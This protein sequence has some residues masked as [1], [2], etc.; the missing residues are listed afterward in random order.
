MHLDGHT[1]PSPIPVGIHSRPPFISHPSLFLLFFLCQVASPSSAPSVPP[2]YITAPWPCT[3]WSM[4]LLSMWTARQTWWRGTAR[5]AR[6]SLR[7]STRLRS[8]WMSPRFCK[9]VKHRGCLQYWIQ[10]KPQ[11]LPLPPF[12]P[13]SFSNSCTRVHS[14]ILNS[15]P[16]F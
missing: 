8:S 9:W 2:M 7:A 14:A 5:G 6:V 11:F 4:P 10:I 12:L 15:I 16:Q 3:S 13:S 1:T